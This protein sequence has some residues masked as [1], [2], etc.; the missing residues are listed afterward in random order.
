MIITFI[1]YY[2]PH[3][4]SLSLTVNSVSQ[5]KSQLS[6]CCIGSISFRRKRGVVVMPPSVL[7][8][9]SKISMT[10]SRRWV[11]FR[12]LAFGCLFPASWPPRVA[13]VFCRLDGLSID[14][15]VVLALFGSPSWSAKSRLSDPGGVC[16]LSDV[17]IHAEWPAVLR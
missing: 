16:V 15:R 2:M 13:T 9:L 8:T 10:Y 6:A 4:D 1:A 12:S 14:G 5:D 17:L 7:F 3:S 11:T